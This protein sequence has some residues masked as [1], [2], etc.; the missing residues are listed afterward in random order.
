MHCIPSERMI[1][2]EII[3]TW[4]KNRFLIEISQYATVQALMN[5]FAKKSGIQPGDQNL[6]YLGKTISTEE[7]RD[8]TL[9]DVGFLYPA[10]VATVHNL[11]KAKG[12]YL[13]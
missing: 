3:V 12:G 13:Q 1:E 4:N 7:K 6:G 9:K 10:E 11:R 5:E 2:I 8:L